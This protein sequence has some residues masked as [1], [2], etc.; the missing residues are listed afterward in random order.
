[1]GFGPNKKP[2]FVTFSALDHL[3]RSKV[4]LL[5]GVEDINQLAAGSSYFRTL[6]KTN[7]LA[8]ESGN[9]CHLVLLNT[10]DFYTVHF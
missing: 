3:F 9:I 8:S 6:V 4:S 2:P 7:P 10:L 5:N 1:M